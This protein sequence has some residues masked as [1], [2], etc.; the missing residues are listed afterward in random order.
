MFPPV[1]CTIDRKC[2]DELLN[3][4]K[5]MYLYDTQDQVILSDENKNLYPIDTKE[6][7][8]KNI[9]EA[10]HYV[11]THGLLRSEIDRYQYSNLMRIQRHIYARK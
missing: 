3:K 6:L 8:D 7:T 9:S 5:P 11:I 4:I 10:F 1:N 2:A